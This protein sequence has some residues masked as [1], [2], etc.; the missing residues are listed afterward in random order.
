MMQAEMCSSCGTSRGDW[1]DDE[2]RWHRPALLEAY[3]DECPGC[4]AA[5]HAQSEISSDAK[6]QR[7]R[8]RRPAPR[9]RRTPAPVASGLVLR[10]GAAVAAEEQPVTL[11]A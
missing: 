8:F 7:V 4:V 6:G 9:A 5:G 3:V 2:G 1:L 10:A 11:G